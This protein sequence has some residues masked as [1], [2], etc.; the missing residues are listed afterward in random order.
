MVY[1][2]RD[3]ARRAIAIHG[4]KHKST[5]PWRYSLILVLFSG[6]LLAGAVVIYLRVLSTSFNLPNFFVAALVFTFLVFLVIL[7]VRYL[8]LIWFAFLS[9]LDPW[10]MMDPCYMPL[11]S[12]V[13]PAYN[14]GRM[15]G[16]SL[17]SLV[18]LRYPRYE[19]IVVDDGSTDD[20]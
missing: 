5:W 11:V 19:V 20:T 13:V 4:R 12:I 9:H 17:A 2:M 18:S 6:A 14:E 8:T 10:P 3:S 16:A 15:I 1:R 7:I